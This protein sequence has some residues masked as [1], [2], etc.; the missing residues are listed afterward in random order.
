MVADNCTDGTVALATGAGAEVFETVGTVDKK[1]GG[2]HQALSILL[3]ILTPADRILVMD[4]DGV[5]A[6]RFVETAL[7]Q[8]ADESVGAVGGVFWANPATD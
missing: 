1:A 5:L 8:P 2:L 3:E 7:C 4:A 6:P